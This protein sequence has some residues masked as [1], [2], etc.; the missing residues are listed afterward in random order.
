MKRYLY[1]IV[2]V[3]ISLLLSSC[4]VATEATPAPQDVLKDQKDR[5][6]V[7]WTHEYSTFS[8]GLKEKWVPE[9][10]ASHP[11][12]RVEYEVFPYSGAIVSFDTKLLAEVASGGGP[13]VWAMASHNFTQAKY[14][15]AGL[16]APLNPSVFGYNSVDDIVNDYPPNSLSVF[17]QDGKIYALPN[18]VTTL[19]LFYNKNMFDDA[20]IPYLPE[21]KPVSWQTIGEI[22]Q[23]MLETDAASSTPT[24]MGYQFGFFANYPAPEW[25]IQDFYP[26]MRQYGQDD[27]Y[28]DGKPAGQSEAMINAFQVFYD[29]TYKYRAYDPYF[30]TGWFS[31]FSNNRVAMVTAGPW[32]PSAIRAENP[33]VRFGVAP[34]P[35]VDP[36][37]TSTYQNVMYS[38][39]WV[40]NANRDPEQQKLAQEF[41]AFILGKKEE[42]EQHLWWF[43]NVGV[44]QPSTAFL[45]SSGYQEFL[46]Q[47]P[48]MNCFIDTFDQYWVDYYQHSSD[49]TGTA[50]VRAIN[51]VVYD[52]M[53]PEDTAKLLQNELLLLP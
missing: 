5:V 9:F 10:E 20:G 47:E 40:V 7:L 3:V 15:E 2:A 32:Y 1:L 50:L 28:K 8:G 12:V 49:E 31:D 37:D 18:E 48:W 41:L 22:S 16:L 27:L 43:E 19:C 34:H 42:S 17:I 36:E 30:A 45:E 53:S 51:R 29:F 4:G 39:G 25:Y 33:D 35:V 21:D 13:D 26:V 38:F 11:G 44:I 23:Q 46:D 14:I 24:K 52:E 6:L